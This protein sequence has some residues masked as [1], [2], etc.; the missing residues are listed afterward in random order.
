MDGEDEVLD[1]VVVGAVCGGDEAA[2]GGWV[3]EVESR[4]TGVSGSI[5]LLNV[6]GSS[7]SFK[8]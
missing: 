4:I 2:D 3:G 8:E 7:S 6:L 5:L 1:G